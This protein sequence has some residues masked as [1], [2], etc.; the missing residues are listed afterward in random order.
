MS[1][2]HQTRKAAALLN[3]TSTA[4]AK[5][6]AARILAFSN[7]ASVL[8]PWHQSEAKRMTSE[9]ITAASDGIVAA[10]NAAA[11]LPYKMLQLGMRPSSWS[12]TGW[13]SAWQDAV[14]LWVGVGNAALQPAKQ[15]VI[16]ND[17]RLARKRS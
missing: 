4:S 13:M 16:S 1:S 7:P 10:S 3:A 12:P 6:I 5:V 15:T 2:H 9:K 8:S 17:A 11:K 14:E